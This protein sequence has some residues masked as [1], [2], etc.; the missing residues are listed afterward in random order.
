MNHQKI[1]NQI[2]ER[3]SNRNLTGYS[4]KHH[5]IPKCMGGPDSP[6]NL[7]ELT[8]REH[9][10]CHRL[11]CEIYPN[12]TQLKQALFFMSGNK[13]YPEIKSGKMYEILKKSHS[14]TL[15]KIHKNKTVSQQT[16][17]KISQ[18]NKGKPKPEYFKEVASKS[19]KGSTISEEHKNKIREAM[20]GKIYP[21]EIKDKM[22]KSYH[23]RSKEVIEKTKKSISLAKSSPIMQ[24]DIDGN[25]LKEWPSIKEAYKYHKGDI[26]A[27]CQGKQRTAAGFIWRYKNKPTTDT[28]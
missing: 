25:L 3:A 7:I 8:A 12:N 9:F 5:I 14:D 11:L 18:G 23:Q 28:R 26:S 27:C 15:S 16:R 20:I 1:Y 6:E 4:E 13:K 2:I 17:E 10:I 21:K 24:Y 19:R 22:S